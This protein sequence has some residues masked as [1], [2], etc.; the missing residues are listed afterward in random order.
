MLKRL[1]FAAFS[2]PHCPYEDGRAVD[3]LVKEVRR[4]KPQ[5]I[6]CLGDLFE[7]DAASRWDD[8]TDHDLAEEYQHGAELLRRIREAAPG[9]SRMVWTLGN[10]D[11]NLYGAG[12]VDPDLRKLLDW[13]LH[14][15]EFGCWRQIPYR[16][17]VHGVYR[18]GAVAFSHGFDAGR[19]SD[20]SEAVQAQNLLGGWPNLLSVRGH[21]HRPADP[22]QVFLTPS[23]PLHL[24]YAN[25]GTIGP[26]KPD[27][28]MRKDTSQWGPAVVLGSAQTTG[29]IWK[30]KTWEAETVR[31]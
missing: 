7:M 5:V 31:L 4:F 17:D 14:A 13:N 11:D 8:E 23:I 25:A 20:R 3:S 2:C 28:M 27:Y 9:S 1:R 19:A 29:N 12:R 21:T 18:V 22:T 10:H 16:K 26:R 24:W 30:G 15:A 6:V